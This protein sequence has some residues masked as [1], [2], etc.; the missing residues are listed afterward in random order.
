[1][2]VLLL[3][4]PWLL[5]NNDFWKGLIGNNPTIGLGYV[6]ASLERAGFTVE[7]YD[8][9]AEGKYLHDVED[10]IKGCAGVPWIGV[11]LTSFQYES[12]LAI[13]VSI[14]RFSPQ[15]N[16][17]FGGVHATV[18]SE[19][20][21][22]IPEVDF[23][24]RNE[25][26]ETMVELVQGRPLESIKG[27]SYKLNGSIYHNPQRPWIVNLDDVP[28]PS[29]HLMPMEQSRLTIGNAKRSPAMMMIGSRGCPF[30][31]AFCNNSIMGN[32]YRFRSAE[33]IIGEIKLL[34]ENYG[35]KEIHFQDDS[36]TMNP[37]NV[38]RFCN[39]IKRENIDLTWL[40]MANVVAVDEDMLTQMKESGCHQICFGLESADESIL[41][42]LRKPLTLD[43]VR[44]AVALTKK[45]GIK[46]RGSFIVGSPGE[47]I[48]SLKKTYD[49]I[50][51][52]DLDMISVNIL[53]PV[54][55]SELYAW[56]RENDLFI[57]EDWTLYTGGNNVIKLPTISVEEIGK[58]HR[59]MYRDFY[60]RPSFV[61]KQLT[62]IKSWNDVK[63]RF[64]IVRKLLEI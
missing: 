52:L 19:E 61:F 21:I 9:S 4:P 53:F 25:G 57:T 56:A 8:A 49:F 28:Y 13:A 15:S 23:V 46:A 55:G 35:I 2:D 36:F 26:E 62:D 6:A 34:Q 12:A 41:K 16:V 3:S 43:K 20:V 33:N 48:E 17:V 51:E 45:A 10:K 29:Y 50:F 30:N 42:K 54:P 7:I 64:T 60:L 37:D 44:K 38:K 40:C 31:C 11:S 27:L 22:K 59:K 39:L 24:V 32:K 63:S 47:T 5:K 58:W 14:K 1:M 18:F